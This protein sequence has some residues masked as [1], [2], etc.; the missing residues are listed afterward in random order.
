MVRITSM[1]K[2]QSKTRMVGPDYPGTIASGQYK[3]GIVPD[4]VHKKGRI[5]A[6]SRSSTLTC[7]A[8]NQTPQ[9]GLGQSL[10]V[11]IGS[12]PFSGMNFIDYL[13]V[14]LSDASINGIILVGKIGGS[15][16]EEAADFF[17]ENNTENGG[18]PVV[19]FIAG[20]SAPPGCDVAWVMPVLSCLAEKAGPT[21]RSRL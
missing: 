19:C 4:F 15:A 1:L 7:K 6:V 21:P 13:K 11:G 9:A 18:K 17:R 12:D 20:I 8:V 2:A 16:E 10:V 5:G 14:F 3:I